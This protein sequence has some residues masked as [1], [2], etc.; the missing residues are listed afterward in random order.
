MGSFGWALRYNFREAISKYCYCFSIDRG[1]IKY[2]QI[3]LRY[4]PLYRLRRPE[5]NY[6]GILRDYNKKIRLR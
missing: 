1:L 4:H 2:L 3:K 5:K 6:I